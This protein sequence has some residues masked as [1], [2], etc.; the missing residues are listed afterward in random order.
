MRKKVYLTPA[1]YV[2]H[3]FGGVNRVAEL[4][5]IDYSTV[6]RWKLRRDLHGTPGNVP[7]HYHLAILSL[8]KL[9]K[10]SAKLTTKELIYGAT[11]QF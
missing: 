5:K 2:C 8:A 1:E 11:I 4:L 9:E 3:V 10:I 7:D 6:S